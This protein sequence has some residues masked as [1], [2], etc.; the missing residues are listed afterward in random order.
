MS[1]DHLRLRVSGNVN[2]GWDADRLAQVVSNLVGNAIQH[3]GGGPISL[4]PNGTDERVTLNLHNRGNAMSLA[5]QRTMFEPLARGTSEEGHRASGSACPSLRAIVTAHGG[6]SRVCSRGGLGH[7]IR[8]DASQTRSMT[9]RRQRRTPVGSRSPI[10][11]REKPR[12]KGR[13]GFESS[14]PE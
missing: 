12:L 10:A 7:H 8:G 4:D 2:G 3:G 14:A 6:Q 9:N 1:P 5:M 13:A 11:E